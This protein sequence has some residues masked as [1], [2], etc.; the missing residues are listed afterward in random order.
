VDQERYRQEL[1]RA[2]L[3]LRMARQDL[4]KAEST[5]RKL[6]KTFR[7]MDELFKAGLVSSEEH[8]TAKLNR[9]SAEADLQRART[10]VQQAQAGV[11]LGQ[12]ALDKT[13]IRAPMSG[14][15][16]GLKAEKGE[17]AVAGQTNIAGAVLM[18]ISQ[19]DEMLAEVKVGEL[20]VVKLKAGQPA[21]IQVDALPG[22][23]FSG[24]V[25]DVATSV[26]RALGSTSSSDTQSYR[27]RVQFQGGAGDRAELRPGMSAR[28]SILA[29][30]AR[31]VLAVPLQAI[32]EREARQ[33]KLGLISGARQVVF[34]V[35]DGTAQERPLRT[36][37]GTRS[38]V[39][40]LEGV[41]EGEQVLTGPVKAVATLVPGYRIR[42]R[43]E[44]QALQERRK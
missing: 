19:M 13:V 4:D 18:V 42:T 11:A 34:V 39:Q 23:T 22:R 14:R 15:V 38:T 36:G 10:A 32:Q 17:T 29:N 2:N 40:V 30:E 37:V 6:D 1:N 26:D 33:G 44:A 25:L 7:R 41:A 31:N 3:S 8:Q 12:D 28:V 5:W 21:E 24:Q 43:S 9:D 27:V 20:D 16:T 35:K